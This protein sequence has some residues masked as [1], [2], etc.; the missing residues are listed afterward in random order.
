VSAS[1]TRITN[2]DRIADRFDKRYTI[3]SYEGVRETLLRF[4]GDSPAAV[5]EV[6]C[7]TGHWLGVVLARLRPSPYDDAGS[8]NAAGSAKA[9]AERPILAGVDPSNPMLQ[10]AR[11]AAPSAWLVRARA[12][13]LP[14]RDATFDRI[15]CVNAL[16]HFAD[17]HRFFADARR[18]LKPGG[19]LLTIGKD[20]HAERDSWWVYDYFEETR[21]IDRARFAAVRTLRGEL[22]HAGFAWAESLEADHNEV[23]YPAAEALATGAVDAGFTSQLSV[24]SDDEFARG[25]ERMRQA[26]AAAG[27]ELQLV[28]DFWL[29]ATIGWV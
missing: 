29:Y 21:A 1:D 4:L 19:G 22:T 28:A 18:V 11:I 17:R 24:L 13:D 12:E 26:D 15:V 7:G 14:W 9:S 27:G 6:G 25:V 3:Y 5:L 10:R 16:H 23:S 20:P 8:A 2:Y